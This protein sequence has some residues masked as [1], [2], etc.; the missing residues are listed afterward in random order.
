MTMP[1][2]TGIE[3]AK[4]LMLLKPGIPIIICTGY[5]EAITAESV[6]SAG[7]KDL[8]M[9]PFIRHQIASVVRRVLD[10]I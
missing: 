5:S 3:L 6:K 9:K 10:Q 2:M 1:N 4:K 7:A 8:I